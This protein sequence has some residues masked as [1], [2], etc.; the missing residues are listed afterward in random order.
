MKEVTSPITFG[1]T[2][3][4]MLELDGLRGYAIFLV[5]IWHYF[6][7]P[8][9]QKTDAGFFTVIIT[10]L[11]L[12]WSGVDLFFVL[13]GFLIGGILLDNK[14][15]VGYF[16]A[17]YI[18]RICRI[19]PLYF[20]WLIP[21]FLLLAAGDA[22]IPA[23]SPLTSLYNNSLPIW[24]YLTFTQNLT[25]VQHATFGPD[26]LAV[27]W[28]LA[29]EEQFYLFLPLL[30]YLVSKERL[31]YI[32]VPLILLA[33]IIRMGI[34]NLFSWPHAGFATYVLMPCR[35]DALLL[36]VLGAYLMREA[37]FKAY[38]ISH[39]KH[40][41]RMLAVLLGGMI[42]L[43]FHSSQ[44]ILISFG[45][46]WLALFYVCLLLILIMDQGGTIASIAR[47]PP[48]RFLGSV[49]YGVY[50]SHQA[51]NLL[52]HGLILRQLPQLETIPDLL[53][54]CGALIFTLLI[55]FFSWNSLE[56]PIVRFGHT[57]H[58]Q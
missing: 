15:G 23:T 22:L 3:T 25:M 1:K 53:V 57:F 45:Y 33:P 4:R 52:G 56:K 50:L 38:F 47:N 2:S 19:V 43:S 37:A 16:K 39:R 11:S 24:S 17:F 44:R 12:T 35:M 26:W 49:A 14:N 27:S 30:I 31:P 48:L 42:I 34:V 8:L 40:F 36:G 18:R 5:L 28:S 46:S 51:F 41:Y 10:S 29:I 58:Y 9:S 7:A 13:S 21:F 20:L 6:V 55:S 54:T 32:L